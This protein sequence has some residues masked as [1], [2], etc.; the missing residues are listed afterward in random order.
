MTDAIADAMID[1]IVPQAQEPAL[2]YVIRGA[3]TDGETLYWS[4][5]E[6]WT[7]LPQATRFTES[8]HNQF[9]AGIGGFWEH[10][11]V[12][13]A[14]QRQEDEASKPPKGRPGRK[15]KAK[16]DKPDVDHLDDTKVYVIRKNVANPPLF[17]GGKMYGWVKSHL[18][19]R[20]KGWFAKRLVNDNYLPII[21]AL[22]HGHWMEDVYADGNESPWL[23]S[24]PV[25][26]KRRR[27]NEALRAMAEADPP[28]HMVEAFAKA[29]IEGSIKIDDYAQH[30]AMD[31]AY[32]M[33][34]M[35]S[36]H[37]KEHKYVDS[38]PRL[39]S[40]VDLVTSLLWEIYQ[41]IGD[42]HL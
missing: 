29:A 42:E 30:E 28:K 19:N 23:V 41:S 27:T 10:I 22:E 17:L 35:V 36:T 25:K 32:L 15:P 39:R 3:T 9:S 8:E 38:K 20:Y 14:R 18:A 37:L 11:D 21:Q 33:F 7:V 12:A 2:D 5:G 24:D 4:N 1:G 34:E 13:L 26:S 16:G 6:G 40:K 31:R